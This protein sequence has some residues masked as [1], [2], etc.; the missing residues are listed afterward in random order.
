MVIKPCT[1]C[2]STALYMLSVC[3]SFACLHCMTKSDKEIDRQTEQTD[4][5]TDRQRYIC[6]FACIFCCWLT[7]CIEIPSDGSQFFRVFLCNHVFLDSHGD[8]MVL[9]W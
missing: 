6:K 4:R 7:C 5:Q 3:L 1:A 8:Q 2:T 9:L